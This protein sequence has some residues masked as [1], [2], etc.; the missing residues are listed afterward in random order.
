MKP[1]KVYVGFCDDKPHFDSLAEGARQPGFSVF[2][3]KKR[4]RELYEDVRT[5][6]LVPEGKPTG[7]ASRKVGHCKLHKGRT[8]RASSRATGIPNE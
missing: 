1:I 6:L 2:R 8:L 5:M 7:V 4:A 3:S